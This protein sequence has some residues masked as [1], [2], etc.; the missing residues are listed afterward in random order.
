[1]VV[2]LVLA[3]VHYSLLPILSNLWDKWLCQKWQQCYI[4]LF[5]KLSDSWI[6]TV[7]IFENERLLH[8]WWKILEHIMSENIGIY[9]ECM[10]II[11]LYSIIFLAILCPLK[12]FFKENISQIASCS[13]HFFLPFAP[14]KRWDEL[15]TLSKSWL[16]YYA[17]LCVR[18]WS[19]KY[20]TLIIWWQD[21]YNGLLIINYIIFLN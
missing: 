20:F 11:Y 12:N 9:H 13:Q 18:V 7:L 16:S 6:R 10:N 3:V 19:E 2:V 15:V 17:Y 8:R 4:L 5:Q 1:M 14:S 21:S